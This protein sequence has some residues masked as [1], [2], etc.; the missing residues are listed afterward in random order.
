MSEK[1]HHIDDEIDIKIRRNWTH[2]EEHW[3]EIET[4]RENL[5]KREKKDYSCCPNSPSRPAMIFFCLSS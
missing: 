3:R 5:N 4:W 1:Y 2:V